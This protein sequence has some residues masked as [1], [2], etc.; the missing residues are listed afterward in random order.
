MFDVKHQTNY[1]PTQRWPVKRTNCYLLLFFFPCSSIASFLSSLLAPER[2]SEQVQSG[3]EY[4]QSL[5]FVSY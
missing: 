1:E 5:D 4:D 3:G 2:G